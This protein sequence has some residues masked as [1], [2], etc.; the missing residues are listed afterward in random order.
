MF[1][2]LKD[3]PDYMVDEN[4]VVVS[5]KKGKWRVLKGG[6]DADGYRVITL[7]QSGKRSCGKVHRLV[8]L[9]FVGP[10]DLVVNHRNGIKTDNRLENLEYITQAQNIQHALD[11]GL[12]N[13]RGEKNGHSKLSDVVASRLLALKGTMSHREAAR[14]FGIGKTSVGS[15]WA[16]QS[17]K[18]LQVVNGEPND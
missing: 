15:L 18:H 17:R 4:G 10:S 13:N 1:V 12:M 8:M 5:L 11:N 16:G 2:Q 14:Q 7:M 3:F 6:L 9:A